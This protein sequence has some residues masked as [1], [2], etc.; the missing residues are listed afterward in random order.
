LYVRQIAYFAATPDGSKLSRREQRE[1]KKEEDNT[2]IIDSDDEED[3]LN[4]ASEDLSEIPFPEIP[5][6]AEY[7]IGLFYGAGSAM[8]TGM[9]L[10]PLSWQEIEAWARCSGLED[11]ITPWELQVVRRLSEAYTS[12]YSKASDPKRRPP[13]SKQVSVDEIDRDA[14]E[15]Q[16]RNVL[17]MFKRKTEG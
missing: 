13:Y 3:N 11:S 4:E 12:E 10:V 8:P 1:G 14:I 15:K 7:L 2:V 6:G 9:G 5:P 17:S 16:T